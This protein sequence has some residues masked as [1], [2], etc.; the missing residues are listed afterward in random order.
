LRRPQAKKGE[1]TMEL[2]SGKVASV[3]QIVAGTRQ[4]LG[5]QG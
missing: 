1:M 3:K 4:L 5:G 2:A